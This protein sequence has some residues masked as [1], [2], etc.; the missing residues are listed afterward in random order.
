MTCLSCQSWY[1]AALYLF[2]KNFFVF[3]I[4]VLYEA[5]SLKDLVTKII[6]LVKLTK[7]VANHWKM[8]I[9]I[10]LFSIWNFLFSDLFLTFY[11]I[12]YGLI[13]FRE[14]LR[15]FVLAI[16]HRCITIHEALQWLV[17]L[18]YNMAIGYYS[19]L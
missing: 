5:K 2:R 18:G 13:V 16:F 7:M 19:I 17:C 11:I 12:F 1:I 3:L 15:Y 4:D 8:V 9:F 6:G 10:R 14:V